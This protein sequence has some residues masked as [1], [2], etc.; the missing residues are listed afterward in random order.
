MPMASPNFDWRGFWADL[1]SGAGR[2]LLELD[3]SR[4]SAAALSGLDHFAAMQ[5]RRLLERRDATD[6]FS[7]VEE[8]SRHSRGPA[9]ATEVD[10]SEFPAQ[11]DGAF[12]PGPVRDG[13]PRGYEL[14]IG[15]SGLPPRA[16]PAPLSADPYD[17]PGL[18][19][20][21]RLGLRGLIHRR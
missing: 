8:V 14:A 2:G 20:E 6:R 10:L 9:E 3:G 21:I 5:R 17:H 16:R 4:E 7:R 15:A 11:S 1:L 18:P 12:G 19:T 13:D